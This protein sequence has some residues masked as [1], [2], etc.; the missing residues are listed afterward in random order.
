MNKSNHFISALL[1]LSII[2]PYDSNNDNQADITYPKIKIND[3][4]EG[5]LLRRSDTEGYYNII[6]NWI[7]RIRV[8][9]WIPSRKRDCTRTI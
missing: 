3:I 1:L 5:A 4:K 2:F 8:C 9:S 6:P 7:H